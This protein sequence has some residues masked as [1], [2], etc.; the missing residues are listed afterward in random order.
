MLVA[1]RRRRPKGVDVVVGVVETHGRAETEASSPGSRSS[2]RRKV[3]Y[4]GHTLE[5]MDLD[6]ILARRPRLVLVDELAHSQCARQPPSQAL[7]RRA[8]PARLPASTSIRR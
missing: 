3:E 1:A 7:S 4:K 5:E 6:A 8:G 2:P